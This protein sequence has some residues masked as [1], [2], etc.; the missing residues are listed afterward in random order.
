MCGAFPQM[1][2]SRNWRGKLSI[3]LS[4]KFNKAWDT[5]GMSRLW[6]M[7]CW[8]TTPSTSVSGPAARH[9]ED[10]DVL[11]AWVPR[12]TRGVKVHERSTAR[13][14]RLILAARDMRTKRADGL[15]GVTVKLEKNQR[16]PMRISLSFFVLFTF[17]LHWA[18]YVT[19]DI[20]SPPMLHHLKT[21]CATK[22]WRSSCSPWFLAIGCISADYGAKYL[23]NWKSVHEIFALFNLFCFVKGV[24]FKWSRNI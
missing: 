21:A 3:S 23:Y 19:L 5:S 20:V 4:A 12:G 7:T 1:S 8:Q 13:R 24:R 18:R 9:T 10:L 15:P 22:Y 16:Q 11:G 6:R 2:L 17:S 14:E